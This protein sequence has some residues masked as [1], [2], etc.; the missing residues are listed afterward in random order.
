M[1]IPTRK[2]RLLLSLAL[3]A[4]AGPAFAGDAGGM[5]GHWRLQDDVAGIHKDRICIFTQ[6]GATFAG[7]CRDAD[8]PVSVSGTTNGAK[9]TFQFKVGFAGQ[10]LTIV[11]SGTLKGD[12][13][14]GSVEAQPLGIS[15]SF[16]LT[17]SH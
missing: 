3:G 15:G 8:G 5:A 17:R 12:D 11:C 4:V 6:E 16:T 10:D 14:S 13:G 2:R 9:I 7:T 1:M